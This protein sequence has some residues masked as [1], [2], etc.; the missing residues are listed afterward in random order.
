MIPL[1]AKKE[2]AQ[3]R[4]NI[5]KVCESFTAAKLCKECNCFMPV[6]VKLAHAWCPKTKWLSKMDPREHQADAYKDLE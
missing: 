4:Y 3:E 1:I 2:I 5:C 6:K